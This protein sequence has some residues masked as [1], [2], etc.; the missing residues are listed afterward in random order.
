MFGIVD[1]F[2]NDL[3]GD[4]FAPIVVNGSTLDLT[5]LPDVDMDGVDD[6]FEPNLGAATLAGSVRTGLAG[7]GCS[8]I[9]GGGSKDPLLPMLALFAAGSM[10]F[11][12]RY[13]K[14]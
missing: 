12:R 7:N 1:Q 5:D 6:V 10:L 11:R 2:D 14:H 4:G 13:E 3:F 8:V 9:D